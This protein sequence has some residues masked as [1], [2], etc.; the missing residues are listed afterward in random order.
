MPAG[1]HREAAALTACHKAHGKKATITAVTPPGRFGALEFQ[2]DRVKSFA[3]KPD[4]DGGMINGG[5]F[6]LDPSVL[7]LIDGPE[8]IWEQRPLETL[9]ADDELVAY[10][11]NG[12]WQPMDT[13]RDKL[14]LESLWAQ[15]PP[16]K[17]W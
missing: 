4:G 17:T 6:V 1:A 12:F 10:R 14:H 8:T 15:S 13:L 16:W 5:F 3:E 2:G 9:A 7:D 11:H